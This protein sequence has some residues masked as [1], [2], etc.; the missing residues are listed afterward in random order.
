MRDPRDATTLLEYAITSSPFPVEASPTGTSSEIASLTLVATNPSSDPG[1][2]KVILKY[3]Q[4]E[5]PVGATA[6]DLTANATIQALPP[7]GWNPPQ[8]ESVSGTG[9]GSTVVAVQYTFTP[10]QG[11]GAVGAEALSFVFNSIQVNDQV[12]TAS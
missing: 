4:I 7:T 10:Q 1:T 5:I 2:N 3:L 11:H 6:N 8:V 9:T 12:G